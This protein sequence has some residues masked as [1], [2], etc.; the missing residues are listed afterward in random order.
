[1]FNILDSAE[2]YDEIIGIN[3]DG[4]QVEKKLCKFYHIDIFFHKNYLKQKH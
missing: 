3:K 1:M 4:K 2:S